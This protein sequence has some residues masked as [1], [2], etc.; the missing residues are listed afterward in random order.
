[1]VSDEYDGYIGGIYGL[2][3]R[4]ESD[5]VIINH[6]SKIETERMGRN[7]PSYE[8]LQNVVSKLRRL[9][10]PTVDDRESPP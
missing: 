4:N 6:L 8:R 10:L 2:L 9:K 1:M 3:Q 5:E 7:E